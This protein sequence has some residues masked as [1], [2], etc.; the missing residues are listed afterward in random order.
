MTGVIDAAADDAMTFITDR[1]E[2]QA[3]TS[4]C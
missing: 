3:A 4:T 1:Y 2:H